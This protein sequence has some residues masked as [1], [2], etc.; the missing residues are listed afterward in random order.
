MS[1]EDKKLPEDE[2][3]RA[4]LRRWEVE[5]APARL[6]QRIL[7]SYREGH[8]TPRFWARFFPRPILVP[9]PLALVLGLLL[10][11]MGYVIGRSA[12]TPQVDFSREA[13]ARVGDRPLVTQTDLSGFQPEA[14]ITMRTLRKDEP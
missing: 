6:G 9:A 11:V 13:T 1:D 5:G 4:L 7:R 10:L 8:R 2:K 3:L 12:R 14:E